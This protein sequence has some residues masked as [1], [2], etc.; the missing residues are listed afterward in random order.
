MEALKKARK[1]HS[2]ENVWPIL[3]KAYTCK[4]ISERN[5]IKVYFS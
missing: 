3:V 5:K 4:D 2:F 1:Y